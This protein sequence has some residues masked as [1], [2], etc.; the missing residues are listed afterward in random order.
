MNF[1]GS[2]SQ[3]PT[4]KVARGQG[5]GSCWQ[6]QAFRLGKAGWVK[7]GLSCSVLFASLA[8][9][10]YT[11]KHTH[12]TLLSVKLLQV[13]WHTMTWSWACHNIVIVFDCIVWCLLQSIIPEISQDNTVGYLIAQYPSKSQL[14]TTAAKTGTLLWRLSLN[15]GFLATIPETSSTSPAAVF[16]CLQSH[17]P[18][19][20]F[21]EIIMGQNT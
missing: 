18:N 6:C 3:V 8:C 12:T 9:C 20:Q 1:L 7:N 13:R 21:F 17:P 15:I 14:K 19:I 16:S 11:D 10:T 2:T 4:E 5:Q